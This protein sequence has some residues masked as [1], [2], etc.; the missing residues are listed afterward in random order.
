MLM[1]L[2]IHIKQILTLM[3]LGEQEETLSYG[4]RLLSRHAHYVQ[5]D[6]QLKSQPVK[7]VTVV[8]IT[9]IE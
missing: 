5:S 7:G 3:R 8:N 6:T 4:E 2:K 9:S 1:L